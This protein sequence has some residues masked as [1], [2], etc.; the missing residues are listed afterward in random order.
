[1]KD[2]TPAEYRCEIGA[3]CPAVLETDN[4]KLAIIGKSVTEQDYPELAGRIGPDEYAIEIS[5]DLVRK[6][7]G[8]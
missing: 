1:M 7:L 2:L 5:A 3:S 6:A 8:K 4:G